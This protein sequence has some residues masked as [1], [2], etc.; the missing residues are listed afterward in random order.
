MKLE[1]KR[2]F[3]L[4]DDVHLSSGIQDILEL[5]MYSVMAAM[6]VT[7]LMKELDRFFPELVIIDL[8]A[9]Q[10]SELKVLIEYCE[11]L[12]PIIYLCSSYR[13]DRILRDFAFIKSSEFLTKPFDAEDLLV[14]VSLSLTH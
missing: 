11:N 7:A 3:L 10:R 8:S 5:E 4:E 6:N 14:L 12:Y 1:K 9:G 13:K 2:I